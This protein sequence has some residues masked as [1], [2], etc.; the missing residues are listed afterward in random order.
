MLREGLH[1]VLKQIVKILLQVIGFF[2]P[3]KTVFLR[4]SRSVLFNRSVLGVTPRNIICLNICFVLDLNGNL[5]VQVR[6]YLI[7][8]ILTCIK[9]SYMTL[10]M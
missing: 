3:V 6:K 10:S 7:K 2:S 4:S 1:F 8:T 9:F 5:F